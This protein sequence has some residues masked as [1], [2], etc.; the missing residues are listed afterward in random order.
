MREVILITGCSS[1]IGRATAELAYRRRH[2]VIATARNLESLDYL[3][4]SVIR[5]ELDVTDT[6]SIRRAIKAARDHA[7]PITAIVNN[8]GY[9]E[10]GPIEE[11]SEERLIRQFDTNVYGPIRLI[12]AVLP[13]MR[14]RRY[15]TIVNVSSIAG[16]ITSPF[17]GVYCASKHAIESLSDALRVEL[18]GSGVSVCLVQPG[19]TNTRFAETAFG[20]V[21][22]RLLTDEESPY[23][24]SMRNTIAFMER[25]GNLE[26]PPGRVA[27]SVMKA[28]E[29]P[30]PAPR[31]PVTAATRFL[32]SL[33]KSMPTRW[34]DRITARVLGMRPP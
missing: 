24:H 5:L 10:S 32:P 30:S 1:G 8:A 3:P 6:G 17:L 28:I 22:N 19:P 9:A 11:V 26:V 12:Q 2:T 34:R 13:T 4:P 29:D 21:G 16:L 7:D 18:L 27:S 31:Y 20:N 15:G 14:E 25:V 33:T 23:A